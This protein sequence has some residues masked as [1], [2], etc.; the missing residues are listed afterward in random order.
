[1]SNADVVKKA[2]EAFNAKDLDTFA[3]M[4]SP[5]C[6]WNV[7]GPADIPWA[8]HYEGPEQVK[9][10]ARTLTNEVHFC[11]FLTE[12][13]VEQGDTVIVRGSESATVNSTGK[14]FVS[15]FAHVFKVE[16]GKITYFQEYGDTADIERA[17]H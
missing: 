8:G 9:E 12:S 5:S 4:M 6:Q 13:V 15:L 17:L 11:S 16:D 7:A 3:G 14:D 2:Y 1:M 10:Y